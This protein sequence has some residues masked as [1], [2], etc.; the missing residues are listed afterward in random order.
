MWCFFETQWIVVKIQ[1]FVAF[2]DD[3]QTSPS[4]SNAINKS[5]KPLGHLQYE[6]RFFIFKQGFFIFE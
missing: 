5:E 2:K 1:L 6:L 3:P 4:D